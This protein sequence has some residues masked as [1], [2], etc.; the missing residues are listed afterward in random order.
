MLGYRIAIDGDY[1]P[2]TRRMVMNFQMHAEI[3]ADGIAGRREKQIA[4]S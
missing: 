2:E 1:G 3:V 4:Y